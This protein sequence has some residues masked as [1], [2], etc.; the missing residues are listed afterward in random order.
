MIAAMLSKF[1]NAFT[2]TASEDAMSHLE[3]LLKEV[4][5]QTSL[6]KPR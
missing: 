1:V 3:T 5:V 2:Q 4:A 6:S